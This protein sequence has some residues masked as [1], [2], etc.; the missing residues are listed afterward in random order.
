[1]TCQLYNRCAAAQG[2]CRQRRE[3]P[4]LAMDYRRYGSFE[5]GWED[6]RERGAL[7][8]VPLQIYGAGTMRCF[9][10]SVHGLGGRTATEGKGCG[11]TN[12]GVGILFG[13][14]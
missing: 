10:R 11:M 14:D 5:P 12:G 1:M 9:M 3:H 7:R 8:Q 2:F 6:G 4:Q 13:T